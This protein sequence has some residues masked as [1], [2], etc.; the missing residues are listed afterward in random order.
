MVGGKDRWGGGWHTVDARL[1][2]GDELGVVLGGGGGA[3]HAGGK[4]EAGTRCEHA[5]K[6]MRAK[7]NARI[8]QLGTLLGHAVGD[9]E[10]RHVLRDLG[11]VEADDGFVVGH[12]LTGGGRGFV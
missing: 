4:Y 10:Q 5:P 6:Q 2:G 3:V 8:L 1:V 7:T 11:G 12:D 9:R